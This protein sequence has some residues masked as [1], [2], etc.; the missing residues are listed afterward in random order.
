[1]TVGQSSECGED[2]HRRHATCLN[3]FVFVFWQKF[4]LPE[5]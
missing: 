4:K 1:M 5:A 2:A 3:S